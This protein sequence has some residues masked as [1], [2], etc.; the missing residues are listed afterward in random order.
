LLAKVSA[1]LGDLLFFLFTATF[2]NIL[3]ASFLYVIIEIIFN[4]L[5]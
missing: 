2:P 4:V 5:L 3:I 1:I